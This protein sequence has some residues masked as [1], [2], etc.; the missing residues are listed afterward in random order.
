MNYNF[1]GKMI[2]IPD[3]ELKKSMS[4][5]NLTKEEAIEL[6]LDDNDF[7]VNET[8]EELTAKAK[9]EI[10]RYEKSGE[11]KKRKSPTKERKIDEIKAYLLH[12]LIDAIKNEAEITTIKNEAEF[13]MI[14][15][16][17]TYTVKLIKHRNK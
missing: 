16:E 14:F 10:K 15:G 1:N 13:S 8:V 2:N 4:L 3:A 12:I 11:N 5:L 9:K 6:W 7:T 17:N